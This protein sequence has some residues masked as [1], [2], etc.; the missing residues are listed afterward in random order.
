MMDDLRNHDAH[1]TREERRWMT[2]DP[3]AGLMRVLV[4]AGISVIIGM[5]ASY[6]LAPQAAPSQPMVASAR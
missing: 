5:A 6:A 2:A 3:V 1:P 4:L